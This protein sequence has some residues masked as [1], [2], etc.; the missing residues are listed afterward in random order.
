MERFQACFEDLADPR[1]G[2]AQRHDLL[3]ILLIALAALTLCSLAR[4]VPPIVAGALAVY[5]AAIALLAFVV[6]GVLVASA[7]FVDEG[8]PSGPLDPGTLPS[9][10]GNAGRARPAMI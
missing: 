7:G 1:T 4:D 6:H 9:I 5:A 10:L 2:N 8:R 3:E